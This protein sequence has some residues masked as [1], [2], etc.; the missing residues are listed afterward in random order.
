MR[1]SRP[2]WHQAKRSDDHQSSARHAQ[3]S[4]RRPATKG[5]T[6]FDDPIGDVRA[7]LLLEDGRHV[8][9]LAEPRAYWPTVE[10]DVIKIE[11]KRATD[12]V[13]AVCPALPL[14][15][16]LALLARSFLCQ[17]C[18]NLEMTFSWGPLAPTAADGQRLYTR[19]KMSKGVSLWRCAERMKRSRK[20]G[21]HVAC[22][23]SA[24]RRRASSK[25]VRGRGMR[26]ALPS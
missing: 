3:R 16:A 21:S 7:N 25:L 8:R 19:F 13:G 22:A 9:P 11:R 2:W 6:D 15:I 5:E 18:K 23:R 14:A 4:P 24:S 10:E 26:R 17:T 1:H 12:G 20:P